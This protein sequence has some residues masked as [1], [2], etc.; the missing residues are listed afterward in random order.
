MRQRAL[1]QRLVETGI[2]VCEFRVGRV[3]LQE[4]YLAEYGAGEATRR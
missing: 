3:G 2:P 4:A 1:L